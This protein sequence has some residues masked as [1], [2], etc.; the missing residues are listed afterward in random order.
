MNHRRTL[1]IAASILSLGG[2][3]S[4]KDPSVKII[5][6]SVVETSGEAMTLRIAAD[7]TNPNDE[8]LKL[9]TFSYHVDVDGHRVYR[10]VRAAE[11]TLAA[12]EQRQVSL[13]A[14]VRFAD[15]H[16]SPTSQPV[17]AEY[18]V[19]GSLQYVTPGEIAQIL[20]DS[21]VRKP[22]TGFRGTVVTTPAPIN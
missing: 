10:G 1:L 21:G 14:V 19:S 5:G 11:A 8:P 12:N 3:S 9:L 20:F 4:Y 7:L 17:N 2:C 18:T 15:L 22:K 13:P 16:G 6:A